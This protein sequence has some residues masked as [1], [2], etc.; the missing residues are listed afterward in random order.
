MVGILGVII[1][2]AIVMIVL[3]LKLNKERKR[4]NIRGWVVDNDLNGNRSRIY[5]NYQY[6]ISGR[7]DVL[8]R[9][10]LI[11]HKSAV[12]HGNAKKGDLRQIAA[13][14]VA[15][16]VD[17]AALQYANK[18]FNLYKNSPEMQSHVREVIKQGPM[19]LQHLRRKTIPHGNPYP[20]K[21]RKCEFRYRCPDAKSQL[22]PF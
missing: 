9:G 11:E 13:L 20:L 22:I 6:K 18:T 15:T 17:N 5:R 1:I 7:P 8:E 16:G 4:A 10:R 2:A 14:M 12:I 3:T 19:M 21:C